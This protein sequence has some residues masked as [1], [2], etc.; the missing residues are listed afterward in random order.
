MESWQRIVQHQSGVVSRGQLL[1]R[2]LAGHDVRRML[3]R[4]ELVVVH[5]GVYLDH[6]G[7][8]SWLQQAWAGVL[9]GGDG[10]ALVGVSA[11]RAAEG[12]GRR[13]DDST[14]IHVGLPHGRRIRDRDGLVISRHRALAD[15]AQFN[16]SPP[17]LRYAEAALDLA[18][19]A[20]SE[21][22]A[23]DVLARAVQS[24]RTTAARL[25][26][27][28]AERERVG[29]RAWLTGVLTDL[30]DG[31]CSVLEHGYLHRVERAHGLVGGTRQVRD[32]LPS[33]VV[34]RD[35]EY[36]NGLVVELDGRLFHDTARKRAADMSRDLATAALRD[37]RTIRIGWGQVY[38]EECTTAGHVAVLAEQRARPCSPGCTLNGSVGQFGATG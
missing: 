6:T 8:P 16:T 7:T 22:A 36:P 18:A 3:R 19:S 9:F 35:R 30:A 24:R 37:K 10:A 23:L 14:L 1:S 15:R 20:T 26:D 25:L 32:V 4:R 13:E 38:D 27:T 5:P 34:Y 31:A 29:R 12:P 33:G 2:G 28:M 11:M 17:G 21:M